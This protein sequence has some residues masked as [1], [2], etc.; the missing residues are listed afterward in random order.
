[1]KKTALILLAAIGLISCKKEPETI[2]VPF[3]KLEHFFST[4]EA[5]SSF[6]RKIMDEA[7][8]D[9][10]FGYGAVMGNQQAPLDFT[11]EFVIAVVNPATDEQTKLS[12][13]SLEKKNDN[14]VFTYSEIIGEKMSSIT[15]P[16]L[17]IR[18]DRQYDAPL[19]V[20]K[21]QN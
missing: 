14:L 21:I 13:V 9:S 20:I 1:M 4:T 10:M 5:T 7:T 8:F 6:T 12:P 16:T 3:E 11:K 18:V 2:S 17:L 15:K 19:Q